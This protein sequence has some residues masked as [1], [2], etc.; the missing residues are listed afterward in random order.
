MPIERGEGNLLTADVEALVNTVNTEGVMGKGLALQFK[1]AFPDAFKSYAQACRNQEV[2]V[3]EMHVVTRLVAPRI[4]FN[5]P[6][7]KHWRQPSRLEYIESGLVDL[8]SKVREYGVSSIAIPPL[9]CG[10]GGLDWE[11]VKPLIIRAAGQIPDVRVVV[12]EPEGAP[13]P[14]QMV[15]N[16]SAPSMT[17]ARAAVIALMGRYLE[18]GYD[19]RLSLVEVQKLAYFLQEAGQPLRLDFKPHYYG[20]YADNLRKALRN[21]EGHFTHGMGDG[22]NSPETP[23]ELL[24]GA[25]DTAREVLALD[26]ETSTR[27][28]RVWQLIEGFETPFG[29]EVLA[30]VH[31]VMKEVNDLESV[32]ARIHSWNSRKRSRMKE[33]HIR[34][35]WQR[36][37]E[38]GIL[39]Q[40]HDDLTTA[41][42]AT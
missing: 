12:F 39:G 31:W 9:G 17:P 3:G 40:A 34:A 26:H 2:V 18:T 16:R 4:I 41:R 32:I 22:R 42:A 33:G 8:V 21:I 37:L 28:E 29:M 35:A 11:I 1:R 6:T 20:P 38:V 5:F 24:P 23:I 7:K 30:S 25:L 15:E 10:N 14:E 19:Y 13:K 36:I 27:I